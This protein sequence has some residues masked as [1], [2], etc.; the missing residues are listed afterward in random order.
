MQANRTKIY[1]QFGKK[2]NNQIH[3][4]TINFDIPGINCYIEIELFHWILFRFQ[5]EC[6]NLLNT[7]NSNH[8]ILKR[9]LSRRQSQTPRHSAYRKVERQWT[10]KQERLWLDTRKNFVNW[11]LDPR[12]NWEVEKAAQKG[13]GVSSIGGFQDPT[14]LSPK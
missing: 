12:K 10:L 3:N 14:G 8:E 11:R 5:Y 9:R 1:L 13:C 7:F 4:S 6:K 2:N